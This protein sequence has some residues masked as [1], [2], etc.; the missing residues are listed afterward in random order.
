[1]DIRPFDGLNGPGRVDAAQRVN[2]IGK[3]S[4]AA[5]AR[6]ADQVSISPEAALISKALAIP[7]VRQ[8]KIQSLQ[9]QIKAG[10]YENDVRL[11]GALDRFLTENPDVVQE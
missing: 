6:G 4:A 3:A 5:A 10:T 1:M 8:D 9:A 7:D 2:K 11:A